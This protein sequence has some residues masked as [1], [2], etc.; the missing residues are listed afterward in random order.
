VTR[1]GPPGSQALLQARHTP[2]ADVRMA[3]TDRSIGNVSASVGGGDVAAARHR[4]ARLVGAGLDDVVFMEQVHGARVAVV[5]RADRGAG[6]GRHAD[7][8][9]GADA[10]AT[11][12]A[13]TVLAVLVADCVPVLLAGPERGVAAVHAG[14]EGLVAGVVGAAVTTLSDLAGVSG[15]ELVAVIGPAV[16]P[17]CYELP[18]GLA[19]AVEAAVPGTAARTKAG[20]TSIDLVAG[21]TR[22]LA[23]E[24]VVR[25]ARE[26]G[27]TRCDPDRWF[28]H[29]AA[30]AGRAA[31]GRQAGLIVR[32][33]SSLPDAAPAP[34]YT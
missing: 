27:C 9:R 24:G 20:T 8:L 16:G 30:A 12:D 33:P 15:A 29:R 18:A 2:G 14:R 11:L 13:G 4:A 17:C 1:Q 32:G 26:G 7:A 31:A 3:F 22:Q 10:L 6:A 25:I 23:A 21:V 19:A 34:A 28:S 5:G